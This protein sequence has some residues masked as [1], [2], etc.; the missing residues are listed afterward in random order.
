MSIPGS[1]HIKI[2]KVLDKNLFWPQVGWV[3]TYKPRTWSTPLHV[4]VVV[5]VVLYI[6]RCE[7]L[8][9]PSFQCKDLSDETNCHF[10]P[11]PLTKNPAM[12]SLEFDTKAKCFKQAFTFQP[13][14][15]TLLAE[16]YPDERQLEFARSYEYSSTKLAIIISTGIAGFLNVLAVIILLCFGRMTHRCRPMRHSFIVLA[17]MYLLCVA[18]TLFTGIF[19]L[20][21]VRA[22]NEVMQNPTN[23]DIREEVAIETIQVTGGLASIKISTH[24]TFYNCGFFLL[25]AILSIVGAYIMKPPKCQNGSPNSSEYTGHYKQ[26]LYS[27]E[28]L[29]TNDLLLPSGHQSNLDSIDDGIPTPQQIV[30]PQ[31]SIR[32]GHIMSHSVSDTALRAALAANGSNT[33]VSYK[34]PLDV[35]T[36]DRLSNWAM[37]TI[38]RRT[39]DSRNSIK[40]TQ[41]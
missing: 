10:N 25:A 3:S 35:E 17:V 37:K 40:H 41:V 16:N 24:L 14:N 36:A 39:I 12:R 27:N 6:F 1:L 33:Y 5:V 28:L 31:R 2:V 29:T 38:D 20:N 32:S 15:D 23:S 11:Q 26:K 34:E 7:K 21:Y 18:H 4:V 8:Q 30:T 13:L 22:V 19:W 9:Y